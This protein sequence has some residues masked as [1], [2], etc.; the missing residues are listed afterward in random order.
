MESIVMSSDWGDSFGEGGG[1]FVCP[2][3][4]R[5]SASDRNHRE[6]LPWKLEPVSYMGP[7][8]LEKARAPLW[9]RVSH[10]ATAV[11]GI[12]ETGSSLVVLFF[13]SKICGTASKSSM[14]MDPA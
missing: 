6:D 14:E 13:P 3:N 4:S 5:H 1:C 11:F 8:A 10:A 9:G 7:F 12:Y 2:C